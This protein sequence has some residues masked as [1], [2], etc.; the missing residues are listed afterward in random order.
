MGRRGGGGRK[1]VWRWG[2]REIRLYTYRYTVTI[3]MTSELRWA[4]MRAILMFHNCEGQSYK[5]VSTHHNF[6]GERRSEAD[7][8]WSPSTYQPNALPLGQTGSHR[9]V[10]QVAQIS[11]LLT[12]TMT[13]CVFCVCAWHDNRISE[14]TTILTN[15]ILYSG[16]CVVFPKICRH[17]STHLI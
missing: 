1:G 5:T 11:A 9:Q 14:Q 8:N 10:W 12:F 16:P 17:N 6:W 7:S 3:R 2:K 15:C 13:G 4:L